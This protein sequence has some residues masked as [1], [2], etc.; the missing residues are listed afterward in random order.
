MTQDEIRH[1]VLT[2]APWSV[3]GVRLRHEE[4]SPRA[5]SWRPAPHTALG[6][7]PT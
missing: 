1:P 4:S 7:S 2:G 6:P 5:A 3:I